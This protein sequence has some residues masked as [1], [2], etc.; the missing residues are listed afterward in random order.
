[1]TIPQRVKESV[2]LSPLVR[3][4]VIGHRNLVQ[5]QVLFNYK[6]S[7]DPYS[8]L[9]SRLPTLLGIS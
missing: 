2:A 8:G 7:E 9:R 4:C 5:R 6:H 3:R 1:M